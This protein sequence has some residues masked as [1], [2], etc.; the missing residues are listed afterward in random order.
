MEASFPLNSSSSARGSIEFPFIMSLPK[1]LE[2][3]K[4]ANSYKYFAPNGA[5]GIPSLQI[6]DLVKPGASLGQASTPLPQESGHR[7]LLRNQFDHTPST[8]PEQVLSEHGSAEEWDH[9][10]CYLYPGWCVLPNSPFVSDV[11]CL[12]HSDLIN[13]TQSASVGG[14]LNS[15]HGNGLH[16]YI[17]FFQFPGQSLDLR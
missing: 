12:L 15:L 17:G 11:L 7:V 14:A 2:E 3:S 8:P 5:G 4:G 16:L 6:Q 1:E 10:E 13:R 9:L